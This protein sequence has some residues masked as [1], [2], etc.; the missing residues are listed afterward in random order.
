MQE[1]E[2][3]NVQAGHLPQS[4]RHLQPVNP[5][6]LHQFLASHVRDMD[7]KTIIS[8]LSTHDI[9]ASECAGYSAAAGDLGAA[10]DAALFSEDVKNGALDA[11][12]VL[13]DA[14]LEK[15]EHYYYKHA[16]TFLSRAPLPA[17]KSFLN[18]YSEGLSETRLLPSFMQYERKRTEHKRSENTLDNSKRSS[19][20]SD[21]GRR[22]LDIEKSPTDGDGEMEIKI[23]STYASGSNVASSSFFVDESMAS[24]TYLEGV[25]KLGSKSRAVYNYLASLYANM[26]DEGPLVCFLSAHVPADSYHSGTGFSEIML[27]HSERETS[28]PLDLPYVLRTILQ[29]GRHMR[30]AVKLYMVGISPWIVDTQFSH[31]LNLLFPFEG[32]WYETPSC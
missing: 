24:V 8:V 1:R 13:N 31:A 11:L 30:S 15:A 19:Q 6:L 16:L 32:L 21:K 17:S 3:D 5:A 7:A 22:K 26:Q 10:V 4:N 27:K 9:S 29:T 12:R 25:I 28:T 23:N 2:N 18:R 14:P 20:L